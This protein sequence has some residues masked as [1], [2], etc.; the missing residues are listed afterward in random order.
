MKDSEIIDVVTARRDGKDIEYEQLGYPWRDMNIN[1]KFN[2]V[3][4]TYRVKPKKPEVIGIGNVHNSGTNP[5][6]RIIG[7]E[8]ELHDH[9]LFVEL[10][11]EVK[12]LL[13]DMVDD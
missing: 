5:I 13:G 6:D 1:S 3:D 2:F 8:Y 4:F 11:P 12:A 7:S 10:T 9:K